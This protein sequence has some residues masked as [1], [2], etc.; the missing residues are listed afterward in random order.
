M[1]IAA[2][3]QPLAGF[4]RSH[5]L[6]SDGRDGREFVVLLKALLKPPPL[7]TLKVCMPTSNTFQSN[8]SL[9]I[10]RVPCCVI[11]RTSSVYC[12]PD[13]FTGSRRR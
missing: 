1:N 5:L 8:L 7:F 4:H 11:V 3:S 13:S 10:F 2:L 6:V 12:N 9:S